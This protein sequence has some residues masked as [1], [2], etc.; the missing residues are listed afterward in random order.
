MKNW[1]LM[2]HFD[3]EY[4]HGFLV[5]DAPDEDSARKKLIQQLQLRLKLMIALNKDKC[6]V[7]EANRTRDFLRTLN[8]PWRV[9]KKDKHPVIVCREMT[10]ECV[11]TDYW[12]KD[13]FLNLSYCNIR[14]S[15]QD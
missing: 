10:T 8:H 9:V 11:E 13:V 5:F 4:V 2:I 7:P 14:T 12:L 15:T 6:Y 3:G 1:Y